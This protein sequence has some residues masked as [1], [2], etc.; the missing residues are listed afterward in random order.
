[1]KSTL[2]IGLTGGI[3]SGKSSIMQ[4]FEN[5]GVEV[6]YADREAKRIMQQHNKVITQIIRYFG[7]ESYIDG[8]LNTKHIAAQV[9][10]NPNKLQHLN[11]IV[12]P[13]VQHHFKQ[14][15]NKSKAPFVVYENAILFENGFDKNCD[16]I[17]TVTAPLA[18]RIQRVMKRDGVSEEQVKQRVQ[19]QWSDEDKITKSDFVIENIEWEQTLIQFEIVF[20]KIVSLV[21]EIK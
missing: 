9:F 1:M 3:G 10:V 4:L 17:L 15:L 18:L 2:V 13:E 11:S 8:V 7:E 14:F 5:K 19:N 12:H 16:Y 20:K 6:Y 21:A